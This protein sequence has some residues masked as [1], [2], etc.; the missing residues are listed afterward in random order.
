MFANFTKWA[1][2]S[3]IDLLGQ[4]ICYV[5]WMCPDANIAKAASCG[6]TR[7]NS[8]EKDEQVFRQQL[9]IQ[10]YC[11]MLV[12]SIL[13]YLPKETPGLMQ[14]GLCSFSVCWFYLL[15]HSL[16]TW[17]W[18]HPITAVCKHFFDRIKSR[19]HT[20]KAYW[21]I[22]WRAGCGL[23]RCVIIDAVVQGRLG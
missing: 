2:E 16:G 11:L 7:T 17:T 14:N 5:T 9:E 21:C 13:F 1:E 4:C 20:G 23:R 6:T 19:V 22:W 12:Y 18:R 8:D 3:N 15:F 10:F